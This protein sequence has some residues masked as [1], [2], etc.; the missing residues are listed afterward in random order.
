M[1]IQIYIYIHL[2][3]CIYIYIFVLV[4]IR[5]VFP[6]LFVKCRTKFRP[7][8]ET[9][10]STDVLS[11]GTRLTLLRPSDSESGRGSVTREEE[12]E[13]RKLKTEEKPDE[14]E[15]QCENDINPTAFDFP[16]SS[17]DDIIDMD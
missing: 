6:L 17:F 4:R 12:E 10:T 8:S 9:L 13:D 11:R 16:P 5:S 1:C 15:L 14:S 3:V 7:I 2:C